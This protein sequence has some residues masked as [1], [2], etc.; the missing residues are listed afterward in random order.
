MQQNII[1]F[2]LG[3]QKGIQILNKKIFLKIEFKISKKIFEYY[4]LNCRFGR[5][6]IQTLRHC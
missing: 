5:S 6:G 3:I 4:A 1:E 2:K